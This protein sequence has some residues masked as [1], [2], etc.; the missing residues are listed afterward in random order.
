[1]PR[2]PGRVASKIPPGPLGSRGQPA[3][4]T[5]ADGRS[6]APEGVN[7]GSGSPRTQG[8]EGAPPKPRSAPADTDATTAAG[9]NPVPHQFRALARRVIRTAAKVVA[10]REEVEKIPA[11][12][13]AA[14][15]ATDKKRFYAERDLRYRH[16]VF[17]RHVEAWQRKE[18]MLRAKEKTARARE[19]I[20][21]YLKVLVR[22]HCTL[23]KT[24]F[25]PDS[26]EEAVEEE[27]VD[28][29]SSPATS[30]DGDSEDEVPSP[31]PGG[32][33]GNA[34]VEES[35]FVEGAGPL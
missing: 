2:R 16:A 21:K 31:T 17:C 13:R 19:G 8:R 6:D 11:R 20:Y 10:S 1:M 14:F 26:D 30:D 12:P 3:G 5:P 34:S 35:L 29:M 7:D 18:A 25:P 22:S 32:S 9:T 27:W 15:R 28:P 23:T 24:P 4:D 33:N